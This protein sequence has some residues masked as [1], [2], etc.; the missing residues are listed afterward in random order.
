[1]IDLNLGYNEANASP[2]LGRFLCRA[3]EMVANVENQS[4]IR[5]AGAL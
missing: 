5:Y 4:I 3:D 2:L 1:M